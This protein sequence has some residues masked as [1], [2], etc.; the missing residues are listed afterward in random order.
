MQAVIM[1]GGFGTRLRPITC[2]IPKPMAPIANE[3]MLCHII[4]LLKQ[5]NFHD[6][7]MLLYYQ[8]EV[9][10]QYFGDGKKFGVNI[11]YLRPDGDLGTAGSVK[12]AQKLIKDTFLVI[13]GDV[14]TDFDLTQALEFHK[15]KKSIATM[16]LTRVPNPLQFGVVITDKHG[17][18]EK[19]LEKPSWGEVFSDSINTGIYVLD[20]KVFDYIP[21]DKDF[22]FSK[23]LFPLL[24]KEKKP[25]YG[26]IADGYWKDIGSHDEYRHAH[27]D[28][29]DGVVKIETKGK[30]LKIGGNEIT[31][32]EGVEIGKD[33][34]VDSNAILGDNVII[35]DGAKISRTVIGSNTIIGEGAEVLGSILWD[36]VSIGNEARLKEN[37]IGRSTTIGDR[38]VIQVGTVISDECSIGGDVVIKT[39]LRIWPNK[40]VE[41]GAVLSSSLVW[42]EK[43]N[44][45]LFNATGITGLAN[46]E[47]TPEFAAKI[48]SAYGAF[49][50]KGS[51]ILTTRDT[52][53]VSRMI[54]RGLI[55]GLLSA[56]VKVGDLSNAPIP[57]AR[58]QIGN[59]GEAGGIHVRQSPLD[60][61]MIDIKFFNSKGRDISLKQEK[62]IEQLFYRED[63]KRADIKDIGEIVVPPRAIDY[64]R[65]GYLNTIK[66][67]IIRNSNQK[68]VIDYANSSA[69]MIFP[70]ILGELDI[71]VVALNAFVTS[72]ES[73]T[74]STEEFQNSLLQLSNIVTTLES[75]AGFLIDS[76]AEKLFFVDEKGRIMH[77]DLAMFVVTYLV[78]KTNANKNATIAVPVYASSVI[79]T[80]AKKFKVKVKRTGTTPKSIMDAAAQEDVIFVGDSQGG[81][82]FPQ[83][84]ASFDAMFAIGKVIE[85]LAELKMSLSNIEKQIPPLLVLHKA[86]ACPW[87]KK[88]QAMRQAIEYSKDKKAELIDG[89]KIYLP[90]NKWVLMSPDPDDAFFHIWAE[91]KKPAEAKTIIDSYAKLVKKWQE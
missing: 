35:K 82:I 62:S 56:G 6:L 44:K 16:V 51:Y 36:N 42:G 59:E 29:L 1:A 24:L 22:D 81:F 46:V 53:R 76:G 77:N 75:N 50:G 71:E 58:Y 55:S 20:P 28:I 23:E 74:K 9:I 27:Y 83:F 40:I 25:L 79:D 10:S 91:A 66:K 30:K 4:N 70:A 15:R 57:V 37:V 86:V 12:F 38:S 85:M 31:V 73:K 49:I 18:I 47:I 72:R 67:D 34:S 11:N 65:T 63:F 87:D 68:L 26:Y 8:P 3:P 52:H 64:Y 33:V 48:G 69:T 13:S 32:G 84:Q 7:T 14:L 21:A 80:L 17:K 5:H 60:A 78:L 2:N 89:V 54:K 61:K 19:F 41:S 90:D 39:N 45:A 43:W 88:G